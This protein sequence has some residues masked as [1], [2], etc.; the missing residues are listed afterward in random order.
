MTNDEIRYSKAHADTY[1]FWIFDDLDPEHGTATF[2]RH[3]GEI[4]PENFDL[5]SPDFSRI[6]VNFGV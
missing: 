6:V 3:A 4:A 2:V 5:A 1:R